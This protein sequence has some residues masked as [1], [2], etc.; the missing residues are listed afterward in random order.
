[1]QRNCRN[2]KV[3]FSL[4]LSGKALMILLNYECRVYE[5]KLDCTVLIN[6]FT[7]IYKY[8]ID[9]IMRIE[10][11]DKLE[12]TPGKLW[13]MNDLKKRDH[14]KATIPILKSGHNYDNNFIPITL[15]HLIIDQLWGPLG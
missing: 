12:T 8:R 10:A 3:P 13:G 7:V 2:T 9:C 4:S 1:M 5:H 14:A 11:G 6:E 15:D